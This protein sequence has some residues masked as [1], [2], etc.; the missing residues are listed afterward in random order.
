V[1]VVQLSTA[2]SSNPCPAERVPKDASSTGSGLVNR[3]EAFVSEDE[4]AP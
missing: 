4:L 2:Y 1:A 3:V